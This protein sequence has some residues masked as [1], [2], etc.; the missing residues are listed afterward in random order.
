VALFPF[1]AGEVADY[2]TVDGG[3]VVEVAEA[4]DSEGLSVVGGDVGLLGGGFEGCFVK[5]A[6]AL[7]VSAVRCGE[8]I[9]VLAFEDSVIM[10][11][12]KG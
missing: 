4:V 10:E 11:A 3:A 6:E 1:V 12:A 9:A 7:D 8:E 2:V 5:V